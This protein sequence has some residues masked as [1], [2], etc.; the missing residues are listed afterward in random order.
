MKRH[1]YYKI[2]S[3]LHFGECHSD[4]NHAEGRDSIHI[5]KSKT[6][7]DTYISNVMP[8]NYSVDLLDINVLYAGSTT[9]APIELLDKLLCSGDSSYNPSRPF[10]W[11]RG[12][13]FGGICVMTDEGPEVIDKGRQQSFKELLEKIE[14][15][16][17]IWIFEIKDK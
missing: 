10:R 14:S 4:T 7:L 2:N 3:A 5:S 12:N 17:F 8:V 6:T 15:P 1:N 11:Y 16:E 9:D 13:V